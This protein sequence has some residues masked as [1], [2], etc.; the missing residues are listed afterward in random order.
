LLPASCF[1]L[2]ASCFL[3]T[4]TVNSGFEIPKKDLWSCDIGGEL[5]PKLVFPVTAGTY[6][7]GS[8]RIGQR[9]LRGVDDRILAKKSG[10]RPATD[11]AAKAGDAIPNVSG[12][13]YAADTAERRTVA[14]RPGYR[15]PQ[16]VIDPGD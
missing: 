12:A 14:R 15:D 5:T 11:A 4:R 9:P 2:P 10:P 1:L 7:T 8:F 16:A 6:H 3:H 13:G